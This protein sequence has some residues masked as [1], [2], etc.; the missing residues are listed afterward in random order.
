MNKVVYYQRLEE[1]LCEITNK[2][3]NS[4]LKSQSF[5]LTYMD[6][7]KIVN[8]IIQRFTVEISLP[9]YNNFKNINPVDLDKIEIANSREYKQLLHCD[10]SENAIRRHLLHEQYYRKVRNNY[11]DACMNSKCENKHKNCG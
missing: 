4:V 2:I 11:I 3:M 1:F 6:F 10:V 7:Q 5:I 9:S 8:D